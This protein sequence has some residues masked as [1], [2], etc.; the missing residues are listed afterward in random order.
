M[1]AILPLI[2][3]SCVLP[4]KAQTVYDKAATDAF[5]VTRMVEKFHLSPKQADSEFSAA[6]FD[7]LLNLL[8]KDKIFFSQYD[9]ELLLPF[10]LQLHQEVLQKKTAFLRLLSQRFEHRLQQADSLVKTISARP[11]QFTT[12][13]TFTV[14]E[15]K[16]TPENDAAV[17]DKLRKLMKA[18]VLQ[19]MLKQAATMDGNLAHKQVDSLEA[20]CRRKLGA[21]Y[22][23]SIR[24]KLESPGGVPQLVAEQYCQ[25][26]ASFY[27]PHTNY[28]SLTAKENFESALG[29]K[30]MMFGFGL[31]EDDKGSVVISSLKPGSPAWQCGQLNAGDRVQSVQWQ[32]KTAIDV[33]GASLTELEKVLEASNHAKAI[34]VVKKQDGS[35]RSVELTKAQLEDDGEE[36]RVKSI[37]LKGSQNIGYVS[38]PAFYEDWEN[39]TVNI[40]GCANDVAREIL[41]LKK[42]NIGALVLD[43]RYNG[44]GSVMEAVELAGIFIDAGPMAM[45]QD[46][47]A[48]VFSLKD[49]NRGTIYEGPLLVM[50]N[51]YSASAAELVAATLQD[52]NRALVVGSTS[53]GKATGQVLLPLD[54]AIVQQTAANTRNSGSFIKITTSKLYRVNGSTAQFAGVT[55]DIAIPDLMEAEPR[56]ESGEPFALPASAIEPNK[57]YTP[58]PPLQ[59]VALQSY[60]QRIIDTTAYFNQLRKFIQLKKAQNSKNEIVLNWNKAV[61]EYRSLVSTL[62]VTAANNRSPFEAVNHQYEAQ[63]VSAADLKEMNEQWRSY[64]QGDPYLQLAYLLAVEMITNPDKR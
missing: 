12:L 27:D 18:E 25:A 26:I 34:I 31:A 59:K 4:A 8:D 62:P 24:R 3:L 21:L 58:L 10:R 19:L 38:L 44:G 15:K 43:L 42:E 52:Y 28:M 47:G 45:A 41:K 14:A 22:S 53:Y 63:R 35:S 30:A 48:K 37:I 20:V 23:S 2:F 29:Q 50:I 13:E 46:R 57:Y 32:G 40:N 11:F 39:G 49:V 61:E 1:K 16:N 51:G 55:P 33:S 56:R 60:V 54:T 6:A 5:L 17:A 7:R 9:L 64:L 36:A